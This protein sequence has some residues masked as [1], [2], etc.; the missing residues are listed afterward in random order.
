MS[1]KAKVELILPLSYTELA[2]LTIDTLSLGLSTKTYTDV[3]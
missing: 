1:A 2:T 3:I